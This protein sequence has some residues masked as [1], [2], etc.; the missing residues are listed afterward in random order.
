MTEEGYYIPPLKVGT[1][2]TTM[3]IL[4]P[5][6]ILQHTAGEKIGSQPKTEKEILI[7]KI[8]QELEQQSNPD[9]TLTPAEKRITPPLHA[10]F[11]RDHHHEWVKQAN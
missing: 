7:R 4:A 2:F 5:L 11:R 1:E 8:E 9:K 3:E 6:Q 10:S